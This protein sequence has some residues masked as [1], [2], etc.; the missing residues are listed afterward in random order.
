MSS[1]TCHKVSC[2]PHLLPSVMKN[3]S[4]HKCHTHQREYRIAPFIFQLGYFGHCVTF[5]LTGVMKNNKEQIF[6][7][8]S[9]S[10]EYR[11]SHSGWL[12]MKNNE[13]KTF[14]QLS[15]SSEYWTLPF[16]RVYLL[17]LL[18]IVIDSFKQEVI[19]LMSLLFYTS[20]TSL[21]INI[22][23]II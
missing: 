23:P 15:Q 5:F 18:L 17:P 6:T 16:Y 10:S 19:L 21:H 9:H 4:S 8:L 2:I 1:S 13:V 11:T 12:M 14:T 7:H 3:K 22:L 20:S